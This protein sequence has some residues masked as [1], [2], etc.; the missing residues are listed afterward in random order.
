VSIL[1]NLKL[2]LSPP[3]IADPDFGNLRFMFI[4]KA[5]ERSYWE[6]EWTFSK[7]ETKIS[8][9]L[10]GDEN[11]P[12]PESRQFYLGLPGRFEQI[13]A[14]ARPQLQEVFVRWFEQELPEDI[15]TVVKL[16][17]FGLEDAR[18]QPV[19]WDVSF[20]TTG[21]LWLSITIPFIGDTPQQ[22]TVDT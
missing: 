4:A 15:F 17:G 3:R 10:P 2:W 5:P 20:E 8:I 6:C 22:A 7:T 9:D 12:F 1:H 13:L 19:H 16:A 14:T 11:G 21:D 18:R